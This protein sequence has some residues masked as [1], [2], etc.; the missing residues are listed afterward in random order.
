MKKVYLA[1]TNILPKKGGR[2][3]V[4]R[5]EEDGNLHSVRTSDVLSEPKPSPTPGVY[6]VET[7]NS[8]YIVQL[9]AR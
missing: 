7:R 9:M 3:M 5:I 8:L 4:K 2:A 6:L 1:T